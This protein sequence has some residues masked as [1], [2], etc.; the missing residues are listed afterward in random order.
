M[1]FL[2]TFLSQVEKFSDHIAIVDYNGA[3]STTYQELY[4]LSGRI[5]AKLSGS[6]NITGKAVMVCMDRRMEYIAAEIGIM[7]AGAAFVP[8]LP[9]YPEQR[10]SYIQ[11]DCGAEVVIDAAWMEGIET[12][13]QVKAHAALDTDRALIIYTSGSTGRPKGIV[14]SAASFYQACKRIRGAVGINEGTVMAATAQMSFVVLIMEYY[15]VLCSGGCIHIL[16]EEVRKDVRLI[17][18]YF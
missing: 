9:E 18:E 10:I 11:N 12:Y 16:A 6:G 1:N 14:H 4:E 2:E 3:R 8:V 5:A 17:E 15:S 13:E 7:M